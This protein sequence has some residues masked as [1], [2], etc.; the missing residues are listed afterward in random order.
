MVVAGVVEVVVEL[1]NNNR[2]GKAGLDKTWLQL[3][4]NHTNK[5]LPG[6]CLI[7]RRCG[8]WRSLSCGSCLLSRSCGC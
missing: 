7:S 3:E 4:K 2:E 1:Y 8:G 6:S 5:L